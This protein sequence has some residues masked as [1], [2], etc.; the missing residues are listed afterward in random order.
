MSNRISAIREYLMSVSY[1]VIETY[2]GEAYKGELLRV[3]ADH[4]VVDDVS[5]FGD[6]VVIYFSD[7]VGVAGR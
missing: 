2:S 4:C 3:G 6:M 5:A 7:I 1:V